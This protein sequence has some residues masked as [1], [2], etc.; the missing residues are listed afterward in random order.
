MKFKI[1]SCE[2]AG[3][4]QKI[5]TIANIQNSICSTYCKQFCISKCFED[6]PI[7][8]VSSLCDDPVKRW[9][10][11]FKIVAKVSTFEGHCS[12]N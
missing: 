9:L 5:P 10:V 11:I 3:S 7:S 8:S 2:K 1:S 12:S 6:V 4:E